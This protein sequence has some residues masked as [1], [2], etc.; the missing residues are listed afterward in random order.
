[1]GRLGY[2]YGHRGRECPAEGVAGVGKGKTEGK[3]CQ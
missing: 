1:M 3:K 2:D